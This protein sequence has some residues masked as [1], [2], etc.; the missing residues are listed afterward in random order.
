MPRPTRLRSR[1][2][3]AGLRLERFSSSGIRL[4]PVVDAY[5]VAD[6]PEHTGEGRALRVLGGAA[7]LTQAERAQR[8]AMLA[9]L[10]DRATRLRDLQLRHRSR[11]ASRSRSA[12]AA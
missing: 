11:S 7:D 3:A 10:A 12:L 8:A 9:G 2:A 1:R 4:A 6:L 5:E